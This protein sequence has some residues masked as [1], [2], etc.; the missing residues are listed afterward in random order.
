MTFCGPVHSHAFVVNRPNT[1]VVAP[2]EGGAKEDN[3]SQRQRHCSPSS[4]RKSPIDTRS[5]SPTHE[6]PPSSS[7]SGSNHR[8]RSTRRESSEANDD[9]RHLRSRSNYQKDRPSKS[10]ARGESKSRFSSQRHFIDPACPYDVNGYCVVH[11]DVHMAKLK[12]DGW[13]VL[14]KDCP[15]CLDMHVRHDSRKIKEPKN[16][17]RH[18][19]D[20]S[21][22]TTDR[23]ESSTQ[24][25][26]FDSPP[27][28]SSRRRASRA[29]QDVRNS[30][31][32]FYSID[33]SRE[34]SSGR[35]AIQTYN[36]K[37]QQVRKSGQSFYSGDES[38]GISSRRRSSRV[39]YR[40]EQELRKSGN[41]FYSIDE[42][43][44]ATFRNGA[45]RANDSSE[46]V[47]RKNVSSVY[48]TDN[49]TQEKHCTRQNDDDKNDSC[50]EGASYSSRSRRGREQ[51]SRRGRDE[52]ARSKSRARTPR[53]CSRSALSRLSRSSRNG[54][55]QSDRHVARAKPRVMCVNGVPF[56]KNGCCFLHPH[57]KLASK[58]LLGGWKVHHT[59]CKACAVESEY[60]DDQSSVV[61]SRSGYSSRQTSRSEYS[62][63]SNGTSNRSRSRGSRSVAESVRSY[64]SNMSAGSWTSN[65]SR[66]RV[67]QNDDSF[68]P[69]DA[70]GFCIHHPN[71]QL[72]KLGKHGDWKVLMD[73]C[74]ECAE[75]SLMIGGA[76]GSKSRKQS[77]SKSVISRRDCDEASAKSSRSNVSE[78]TFVEKMPYIDNDGKP[79]HYTGY[80][81]IDGKPNGRGKMKYVDGKKF[82]GIWREG[83]QIHGKVSYK[84]S[85]KTS[86][87]DDR[88]KN[89]RERPS[90][91][92]SDDKRFH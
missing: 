75:A 88:E 37:E 66:K 76:V 73:F 17:S 41:S 45:Q 60:N 7:M 34:V 18:G 65:Q 72:A 59:F 64:G 83:N 16:T 57:V 71:V 91:R 32:S 35:M 23:T 21:G 86:G 24:D 47:V 27:Q 3:P 52:S 2:P 22:S 13:K 31:S 38:K 82:D 1:R 43:T 62:E 92:S 40:D 26:G 90:R 74:P 69:L 9:S 30:G 84:K 49:R 79:G 14:R 10:S 5:I 68:L 15:K 6:M 63:C 4:A 50:D 12:A 80:L 81:N 61:S 53:S 54:D 70:D 58:K 51:T 42:P 67:Q 29:H 11:K 77:S 56:D 19:S 85:R 36:H 78:R 89:H 55:H 46:L 8:S 39:S 20:L 48:S 44:E 25:E 33:E 28:S 87:K